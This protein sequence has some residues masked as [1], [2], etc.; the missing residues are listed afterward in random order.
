MHAV[1]RAMRCVQEDDNETA[2]SI[3]DQAIAD[4][5]GLQKIDSPAFQFERVRSV[6]YLRQAR[7]QITD[8]PGNPAVRLERELERAI[9]NEDYEKAAK[10]RDQ[11][12]DL[13]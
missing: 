9:E 11:I 12:R 13:S 7:D 5:Q 6:N 1:A 10:L 4:I 2:R 3:L 8:S